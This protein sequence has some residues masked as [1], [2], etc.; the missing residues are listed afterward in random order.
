M[1]KQRLTIT[2]DSE[3]LKR[4]DNVIDGSK[5]RNRSHAIEFLLASSL[6][7]KKTRVLILSGG[8]GVRFRP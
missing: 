1:T 7:P 3:L 6:V 4:L 8:E 5:I 2:L